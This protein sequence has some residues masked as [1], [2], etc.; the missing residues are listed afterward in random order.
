[1]SESE[2]RRSKKA[3]LSGLFCCAVLALILLAAPA[4]AE[5]LVIEG[6]IFV[7]TALDERT[8]APIVSLK[9]QPGSARQFTEFTTKNV[10]RKMELRVDGKPVLA[11]VIR[12]PIMGGSLQISDPSWTVAKV[13]ELAELIGAGNGKIEFEAVND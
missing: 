7:A 9:M 3:G 5:P 1:M 10:G 6:Q 13:R 8:K 11:T 12:E 2:N 4:V